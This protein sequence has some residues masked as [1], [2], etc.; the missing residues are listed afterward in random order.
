[1]PENQ[2]LLLEYLLPAAS[3]AFGRRFAELI[4]HKFTL[5]GLIEIFSTI[6]EFNLIFFINIKK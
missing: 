1:M 2:Y 4:Q 5:P 6:S 3:I